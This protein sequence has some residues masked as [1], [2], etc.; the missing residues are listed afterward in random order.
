MKPESSPVLRFRDVRVQFDGVVAVD[1]AQLD[2]FNGSDLVVFLGPNGAGKSSLINAVTGYATVQPPGTVILKNGKCFDLSK[3][4]RDR[5]VRAG[6]TR[7]FQTPVIFSSLTVEE[8]LLMAAVMGKPTSSLRRLVS[9]FCSLKHDR[10]SAM[11]V[12]CLI[13]ALE[14]G[15]VAQTRM[16][17]LSFVMLRRAELARALASQPRILFLDEPSAGA[18]ESET[19]FLIKLLTCKIPDMIPLLFKKGLYRQTQLSIGLVTHDRVLLEGIARSCSD[20]PITH[21]FERGQLRSSCRLGIWLNS[22]KTS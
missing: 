11:L 18:D 15:A 1:L 12:E 3:L 22:T 10:K 4:S 19:N 17:R 6:L 8:S 9:L 2:L 14:L 5:I 13:D 7:T 21:S 16:D 20:E